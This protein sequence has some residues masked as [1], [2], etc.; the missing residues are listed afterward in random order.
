MS[1]SDIETIRAM[2]MTSADI[3]SE[4]A[5][6]TPL[7]SDAE[8][9]AAIAAWR[10]MGPFAT[11]RSTVALIL[12]TAAKVRRMALQSEPQEPSEARGFSTFQP[13]D[14]PGIKEGRPWTPPPESSEEPLPPA[15]NSTA[16]I[17]N[18]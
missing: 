5:K 3:Q 14:M 15:S 7:C 17:S 18:D 9:D 6:Q 12:Q 2:D 8:I 13:H 11:A 4:P 1:P 16:R 10:E